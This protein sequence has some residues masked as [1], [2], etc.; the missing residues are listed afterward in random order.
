VVF[1]APFPDIFQIV[2]LPGKNEQFPQPPSLLRKAIN[3]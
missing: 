1:A 2:Q 3:K